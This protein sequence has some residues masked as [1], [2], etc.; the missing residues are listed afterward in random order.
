MLLNASRII[1][2]MSEGNQFKRVIKI[3][4]KIKISSL[5]TMIKKAN[6]MMAIA[7]D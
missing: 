5:A 4:S 6:G 2:K 1:L 7:N 3:V